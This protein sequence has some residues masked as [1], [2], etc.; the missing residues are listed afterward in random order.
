MYAVVKGSNLI[1]AVNT[2]TRS[3]AYRVDNDLR[4]IIKKKKKPKSARKKNVTFYFYTSYTY[5]PHD[6]IVYNDCGNWLGAIV[7]DG[8]N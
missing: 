8:F 2:T 5:I 4:L 3:D 6:H 7:F 1:V